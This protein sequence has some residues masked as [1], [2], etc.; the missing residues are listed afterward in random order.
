MEQFDIYDKNRILTGNTVVRGTKLNKDELHLIVHV[1][2][3]NSKNEMLIQQRQSLKEN[4]PNMWDITAGGCA[5]AGETSSQAAERET[6]EEIGCKVDLS[7]ER[8]YFTINFERGFDDF[9]LIEREIDID[10]LSLQYEEVQRV[11][12]AS[13]EEILQMVQENLFLN[14]WF[15]E[16]IFDMRKYRGA[17]RPQLD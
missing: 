16:H 8:P 14:Y 6:L 7:A 5:I 9:Y 4:W 1:C 11:K 15:I 13:K 12:W 10:A 2:I 17:L 3:F